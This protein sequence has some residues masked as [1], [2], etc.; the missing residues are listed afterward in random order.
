LRNRTHLL[1]DL[2]VAVDK[3]MEIVTIQYQDVG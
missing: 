2:R 3:A 1:A